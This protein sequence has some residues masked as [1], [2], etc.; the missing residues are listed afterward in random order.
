MTKARGVRLIS[1]KEPLLRQL[2]FEVRYRGGFTYLDKCG[3]ILNLI[4]RDYP[5]WVIGNEI[6]P[7]SAPLYSM[8][9]GCRFNFSATRFDFNLDKTVGDPITDEVQQFID[10]VGTL[11]QVIINELALKDFIRMGVRGFYFFPCDS[12]DESEKWLRDLAIYTVSPRVTSAF[13]DQIEGGSFGVV[14]SGSEC[15]YR[16]AAN[17][18]EISAQMN[19]GTEILSVRAS[20]LKEDRLKHL[21]KQREVERQLRINPGF[22][23]VID[24][25]AFHEDPP[26][27]DPRDFARRNLDTFLDKLRR[28]LSQDQE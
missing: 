14:V 15:R 4:S 23:A 5:E 27:I 20:T 8:V 28:A 26:S 1:G 19:V 7:Q 24:I 6:T 10:Q 16:I 17:G 21:V 18:V 3:R 11:S 12:K 9:N 22:A 13:G 25:D 2:I